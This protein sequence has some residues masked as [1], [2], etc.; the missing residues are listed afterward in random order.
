MRLIVSRAVLLRRELGDS[1]VA[2]T[3][4]GVVIFLLALCLYPIIVGLVKRR[5]RARLDAETGRLP[6]AYSHQNHVELHQAPTK[7][8]DWSR[9]SQQASSS[10]PALDDEGICL[11]QPSDGRDHHV[12][13]GMS[14][15][16]YNASVPPE[17]PLGVIAPSSYPDVHKVPSTSSSLKDRI[18]RLLRQGSGHADRPDGP[19]I[20]SRSGPTIAI[21]KTSVVQSWPSQAIDQ[22]M[23]RSASSSPPSYPAPGTVN[24]MDIMPAST[25]SEVWHRKEQELLAYTH[26]GP[27]LSSPSP[28]S[29][30]GGNDDPEI[31]WSSDHVDDSGTAETSSSPPLNHTD[32][33]G[34]SPTV[35]QRP[36]A[37][38]LNQAALPGQHPAQISNDVPPHSYYSD[39][40]TPM[41]LSPP[42]MAHAPDSPR[43]GWLTSPDSQSSNSPKSPNTVSRDETGFFRCDEPGC[44]QFFDQ[45][46][47][48]KHHQRYHSK[49][50]K[51]TY[52]GCDRAFGTKT[53]LDRHINERHEQRRRFHCPI[54]DCIYHHAGG[55]SFS[56]RDN[57]RRHMMS[58]HGTSQNYSPVIIDT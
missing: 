22:Q 44:S 5:R 34:N 8:S 25:E 24:P 45:L 14:A 6:S 52:S 46:H 51:C 11:A 26:G 10:S 12:G 3:V 42:S 38:I 49:A 47:K 54:P 56:R 33:F 28:P 50:H 9:R 32:G 21:W 35:L 23:S 55:R 27:L 43:E 19:E 2:G 57:W 15:D 20:S 17:Q 31:L 1:A 36:P 4:V 37:V 18:K 39:Q 13:Q 41:D 29:A 40:S 53:H 58:K 16:Y 7:E 30:N 48:L